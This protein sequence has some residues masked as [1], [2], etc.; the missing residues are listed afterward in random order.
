MKISTKQKENGL[1]IRLNGKY[2]GMAADCTDK[3]TSIET[4]GYKDHQ[5]IGTT[6]T[7]KSFEIFGG[8]HAG[9]R[10]NDYFLLVD[11]TVVCYYHSA[12]QLLE[13]LCNV[14][15]TDERIHFCHNQYNQKKGQ[16]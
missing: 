5:I 1:Q 10:A 3:V 2:V 15:W 4:A 7:G 12:K 11:E 9:G 13:L 6:N 8:I 14:E 16:A